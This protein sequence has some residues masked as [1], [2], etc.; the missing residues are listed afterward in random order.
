MI[1][2]TYGKERWY[3]KTEQN[4]FVEKKNRKKIK[5][6]DESNKMCFSGWYEKSRL[7][8]NIICFFQTF[9]FEIFLESESRVDLEKAPGESKDK[10]FNLYNFL[11]LCT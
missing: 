5:N 11:F 9:F 3:M 8:L 6:A 10:D 4:V 1:R 7:S 2:C